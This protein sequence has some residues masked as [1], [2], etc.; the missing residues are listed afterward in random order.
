MCIRDR[1]RFY[2]YIVLG[3]IAT[4]SFVLLKN[5]IYSSLAQTARYVSFQVVSVLTTTGFVTADFE[6]WP[7][8]AQLLLLIL[9][10]IGG[11]AGSTGGGM[12]VV[13][14]MVLLKHAG[15]MCIRDRS[16]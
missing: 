11:C 2:L 5:Q 12:K 15:K 8:Y 16:C 4:I 10:L 3:S 13:R 6:Q 1:F 7:A 9:M 14:V